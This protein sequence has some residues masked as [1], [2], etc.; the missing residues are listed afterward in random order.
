MSMAEAMKMPR[1]HPARGS[2]QKAT[3]P[4]LI[5]ISSP[6]QMGTQAGSL[7]AALRFRLTL[8]SMLH[9]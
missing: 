6:T 8:L 2:P 3:L 7:A 1:I 5:S 4:R 9:R